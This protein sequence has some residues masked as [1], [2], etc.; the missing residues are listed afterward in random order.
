MGQQGSELCSIAPR[1][2]LEPK[3]PSTSH[4]PRMLSAW[5]APDSPG[6]PVLGNPSHSARGPPTR[7]RKPL[8]TAHRWLGPLVEDPAA[9]LLPHLSPDPLAHDCG[10]RKGDASLS[11]LAPVPGPG[12][13]SVRLWTDG[14]NERTNDAHPI[15]DESLPGVFQLLDEPAE[16]KT[17]RTS[18]KPS[19]PGVLFWASPFQGTLLMSRDVCGWHGWECS[20]HQGGRGVLV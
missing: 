18:A 17:P 14:R 5:P 9:A 8:C 2:Q 6:Q 16:K 10:S 7:S 20:W 11:S 12:R 4:V 19:G 1:V 15:V 3:T 13:R